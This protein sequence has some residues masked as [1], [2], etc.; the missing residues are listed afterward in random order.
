MT[1]VEIVLKVLLLIVDNI[2]KLNIF[3]VQ[4]PW[5]ISSLIDITKF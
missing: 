5:T 1:F 3:E 2:Y 4:L